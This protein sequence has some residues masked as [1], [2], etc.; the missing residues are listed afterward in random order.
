ME[1]PLLGNP[2]DL[3]YPPHTDTEPERTQHAANPGDTRTMPGAW[4]RATRDGLGMSA[5]ELATVLGVNVRT[6]QQWETMNAPAWAVTELDDLSTV[7][8]A[9]VEELEDELRPV[10]I[11]RKGWHSVQGRLLPASW[12][13]TTV[14]H[15]TLRNASLRV[16]WADA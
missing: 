10:G 2:I 1:A 7:T 3:I 4:L 5:Q 6:V 13:R 11:F 16:E 8:L 15:A 12:W 9:Y 14:G